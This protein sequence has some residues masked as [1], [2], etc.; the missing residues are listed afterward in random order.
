MKLHL[1]KVG[2]GLIPVSQDDKDYLDKLKLGQVIH[3]D[4]KKM[5]N[6]EFHKKYFALLDFLYDNWE[7][8]NEKCFDQFREDVTILAGYYKQQTRLN[9]DI[10][11]VAKSISFG[12]M[13]AEDF[14]KLYSKTID[15]GLKYIL[16][17]Y[18]RD[19]LD[20]VL[21]NLMGFV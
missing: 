1:Q 4:F 6:Y 17:N 19:D 8:D 21:A 2:G 14:E 12:S 3:A 18:T 11:T 20:E 10:R 9:G 7:T 15:V 16:K 5:R 13:E